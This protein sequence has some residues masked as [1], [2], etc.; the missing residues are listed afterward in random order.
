MR[1]AFRLPTH[2]PQR[3]APNRQLPG[4]ILCA[5]FIGLGICLS[6]V[7]GIASQRAIAQGSSAALTT[8]TLTA[9][10]SNSGGTSALGTVDAV[11]PPLQLGQE[12]YLENCA[13]CHVGV[14][15]EVLP[16]QTWEIIL[17]DPAHY[18]VQIPPLVDPPRLL[19]WQY[20]QQFSRSLRVDETTPY[21]IRNSRFFEVLHPRVEFSAPIRLSSCT[22][23]HPSASIFNYRH[24]SQDWQNAP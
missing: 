24:L 11:P 23:C 15:P 13:T 20:I 6:W 5:F 3:F 7:P 18:G 14:P 22:T 19:I 17:Q 16:R 9:N 4:L 12:L 10:L 21:R 1:F 8:D 2:L